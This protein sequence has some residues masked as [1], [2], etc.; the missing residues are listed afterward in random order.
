MQYSSVS[1]EILFSSKQVYRLEGRFMTFG[2]IFSKD[3]QKLFLF[4]GKYITI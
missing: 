4:F 2:K 3:F 1:L